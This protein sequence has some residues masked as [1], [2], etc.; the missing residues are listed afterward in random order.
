MLVSSDNLHE[1][2][3]RGSEE[4]AHKGQIAKTQE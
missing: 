3:D 1:A 2:K 4:A